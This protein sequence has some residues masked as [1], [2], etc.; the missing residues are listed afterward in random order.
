MIDHFFSL[1]FTEKLWMHRVILGIQET[2]ARRVQT[3]HID[4]DR[5]NN[6]RANLRIVTPA[7]NAQNAVRPNRRTMR[8][9]HLDK[10]TGRW[11]AHVT[12]G[13]R[14]IS[15]GVFASI[16]EAQAKARELRATYLTHHNEARH[17]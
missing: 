14:T 16:E 5:L 17:A 13:G 10:R 8:G 2:D 15:G 7:E 1:R 12:V 11:S 3:D 6:R 4:G 9:V